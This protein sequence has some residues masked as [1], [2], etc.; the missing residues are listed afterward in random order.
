MAATVT[1]SALATY[2]NHRFLR[3]PMTIALL[4][5]ALVASCAMYALV[6]WAPLD[7]SGLA[8][9]V[10][11]IDFRAVLMD[12]MLPYLLM[13]GA[14]HVDLSR[15]REQRLAVGLLA[16]LGVIL[17]AAFT[18]GLVFAAAKALGVD[19]SFMQALLFGALISP[20]DPI[21]VMGI[22]RSAR[23]PKAIEALMSGESLLNDGVGIVLFVAFFGVVVNGDA[24]SPAALA[25]GFVVQGAGGVALGLALGYAVSRLLATVDDYTVEIFLTIGLASG[26]YAAAEALHVSAAL[27]VV[28]AGLVLAS[29]GRE[30]AMSSATQEHLDPFW[31]FVDAVLNAI[32]FVLIGVQ[33]LSVAFDVRH[34]GLGAAAVAAVLAARWASVAAIIGPLRASG[35]PF[36][37]GTIRLLTWGGLRGGISIA[38]VLSL[39]PGTMRSG[40]LTATYAVV[41]FTMLVQGLTLGRVIRRLCAH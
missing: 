40:M 38:L 21:A 24:V 10:H 8:R 16:T 12:G 14:L 3:L 35:R 7:A 25:R 31:S 6:R 4:L 5:M 33:A 20:T 29:V 34:A 17:A 32:L 27:A 1:L 11:G 41:L 19:I 18:A 36:P 39:P 2:L 26:T 9:S 23:A 22:L 28:C 15:M 13:A 30:R 37:H